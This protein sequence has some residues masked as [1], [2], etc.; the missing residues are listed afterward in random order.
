MRRRGLV[1]KDKPVVQRPD[2]EA[3]YLFIVTKLETENYVIQPEVLL[4]RRL[5]RLA[6]PLNSGTSHTGTIKPGDRVLFYVARRQR[7][8]VIAQ[9]R[10][11]S[12]PWKPSSEE[13]RALQADGDEYLAPEYYVRLDE[14]AVL[15]MAVPAREL[16]K[17]LDF[18]AG[19]GRFWGTK[20]QGGVKRLSA[21]DFRRVLAAS[22]SCS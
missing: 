18:F 5:Q 22:S 9:A 11:A 20:L 19:A 15:D 10:V 17:S 21:R 16:V 8:Y 1:H 14:I 7:S 2:D 13:L 4:Q 6:W 12:K 3:Y